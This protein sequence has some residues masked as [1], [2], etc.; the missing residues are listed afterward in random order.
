M[1]VKTTLAA[2]LVSSSMCTAVYA[3]PVVFDQTVAGSYTFNV[4][5]SGLYDFALF[6]A[7]GGNTTNGT[8]NG[9]GGSGAAVTARF[10]LQAGQT[11]AIAV[12]GVGGNQFYV[13]SGGGGSFVSNAGTLLAVAGGGGGA[14]CASAITTA[15]L[16]G[17]IGDPGQ[18]GTSGTA[19]ARVRTGRREAQAVSTVPGE[20]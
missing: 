3:S 13:G 12:G 20:G 11:L 18:A 2:T 17:R 4:P 6:G 1:P 8:T 9:A 16:W 5:T 7:A 15:A 19:V 14:A 10:D